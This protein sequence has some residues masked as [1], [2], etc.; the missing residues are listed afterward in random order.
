MFSEEYLSD[1][2]YAA[3]VNVVR[4]Y[5]NGSVSHLQRRLNWGYGLAAASIDRMQREYI[6]TGMNDKGRREVLHPIAHELWLE[7]EKL[8]QRCAAFDAQACPDGVQVMFD[9]RVIQYSQNLSIHCDYLD[10][11]DCYVFDVFQD[12]VSIR[13][14]MT[15]LDQ[16]HAFLLGVMHCHQEGSNQEKQNE[17]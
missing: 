11:M 13:E 16:A 9:G 6:V 5:N 12:G 7:H 17:Q 2:D 1:A 10:D 8:K 4:E 14:G 3:A 15:L